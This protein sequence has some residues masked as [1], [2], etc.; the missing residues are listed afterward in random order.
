VTQRV[1][2]LQVSHAE[3]AVGASGYTLRKLLRL[4]ESTFIN[5]SVMPLRLATILGLFM[6]ATGFA[7]IGIVLYWWLVD[8]GP[9]FGWG[10]LMAA[11]LTFSGVQLV[12]LGVIGEYLGRMFLTVNQ[13]PQSLVREVIRG[14]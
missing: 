2:S 7:A 8:K 14:G 9:A 5:F 13:R 6:A 12:M 11:L 1:G 4:W 10:S 3:R